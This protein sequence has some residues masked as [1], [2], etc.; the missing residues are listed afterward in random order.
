MKYLI[1][2]CSGFI[3]YHVAQH[4]LNKNN[5]VIGVDNLN[6]YYDYKLKTDR[7]KKLKNKNFKFYKFDLSN[8]NKLKKIFKD[9]KFDYVIHLAAQAGVRYSMKNPYT[10]INSNISATTNLFECC[11]EYKP[12]KILLASSSSVYGTQKTF[13]FKESMKIDKP[14]SF[15]AASKISME[16][17]AYYYSDLY[18]MPV[19]V[20]RFFTVY[21]PWGRPDMAY[22]KFTK[23]IIN[24]KKIDVYNNGNHF[25]DFTYITDIVKFVS[26][27][28]K[29]DNKTIFEILNLGRGSPQKLKKFISIIENKLKKKAIKNYLSMQ[30][31][32]MLGTSANMNKFQKKY[33]LKA[34]VNLDLGISK[35]VDWYLEYFKIKNK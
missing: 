26:Q 10:Y 6:R 22:Y 4:L 34:K 16:N 7:L 29:K 15:Y 13:N 24:N 27:I 5:L 21:G 25:R 28:I 20:L 31:G 33:N 19:R 12:K 17:I 2:G 23:S 1:T 9:F 14:I 3:G 18:K 35:F 8:K 32:D 11:K 30:D